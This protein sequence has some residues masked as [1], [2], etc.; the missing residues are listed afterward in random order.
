M[1][2]ITTS[3]YFSVGHLSVKCCIDVLEVNNSNR[4]GRMR[5]GCIMKTKNIVN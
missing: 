4:F 3:N 2:G 5:L 1:V